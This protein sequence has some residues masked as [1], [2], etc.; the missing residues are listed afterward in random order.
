MD[1]AVKQ[2]LVDRVG[3]WFHSVDLG[4]GVITPGLVPFD[5]LDKAFAAIR[6][7]DLTGKTVL[8]VGAWDGFYS[9][10]AERRGA[11]RVL[12]LDHYVWNLHLD[13]QQAYWQRCKE[14]QTVPSAYH[15]VPGLLSPGT[16]PGKAGFDTAHKILDSKV[17]QLVADYME[18]D[19]LAVGSFDVVFFLGVL[20]HLAEPFK[21]LKRLA[22]FT[23]EL[24]IIETSAVYLPGHEDQALFEFYESNELNADVSNWWAPNLT[25]LVKCCR[26]AGFQRVEPVHGYPPRESSASVADGSPR[27]YR[28]TVH[29]WR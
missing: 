25:G 2:E 20:Y 21:A 9:F 17:E 4:D 24:A 7:P 11:R 3:F 28:L 1:V 29:A 12:A 23:R 8:D 19:P 27:R 15:L 10:E 26:A 16:L 5:G 22:L 18:V 14:R 13:L 6:V